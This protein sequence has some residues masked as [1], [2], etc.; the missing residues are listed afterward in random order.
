MAKNYREKKEKKARG[1]R[2]GSVLIATVVV[3]GA[4][5]VSVPISHLYKKD[6]A[7]KAE[8]KEKQDEEK[9]LQAEEKQLNSEEKYSKSNEYVEEQA[10]SKL[11][12]VHKNETIFREK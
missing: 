7:Y 8:L 2:P 12:M 9:E 10:R 4:V 1:I 6:K 5:F 3:A 11:G